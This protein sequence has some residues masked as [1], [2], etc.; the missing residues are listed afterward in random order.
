MFRQVRDFL[1][2]NKLKYLII[3]TKIVTTFV[4]D[5]TIMRNKENACTIESMTLKCCSGFTCRL[6][7]GC[8]TRDGVAI[9]GRPPTYY[10]PKN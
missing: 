8:T 10:Q 6:F 5:E 4:K 1:K 7:E 3:V 9:F 2:A